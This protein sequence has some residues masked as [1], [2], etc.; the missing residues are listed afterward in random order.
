MMAAAAPHPITGSWIKASQIQLLPAHSGD[1]IWNKRSSTGPPCPGVSRAQLSV[2]SMTYSQ[3]KPKCG[4]GGRVS[5][6]RV[7][8]FPDPLA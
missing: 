1:I 8:S 5:G 3:L 2:M 4:G 6:H 7:G